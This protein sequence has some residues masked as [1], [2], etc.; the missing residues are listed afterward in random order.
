[1]GPG[2]EGHER[3]GLF[4]RMS[5]L[6][7]TRFARSGYR[8]NILW[9]FLSF[10][11]K[12]TIKHARAPIVTYF[13][14]AEDTLHAKWMVGLKD[15]VHLALDFLVFTRS[16]QGRLCAKFVKCGRRAPESRSTSCANFS[17]PFSTMYSAIVEGDAEVQSKHQYP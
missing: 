1:M 4:T 16:L 2:N 7:N 15:Y 14:N 17:A 11:L 12:S 8:E 6:H 5:H 13:P 10:S 9:F 3:S